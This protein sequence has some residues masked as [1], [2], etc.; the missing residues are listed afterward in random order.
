MP[1]AHSHPEVVHVELHHH[2]HEW[3][4][5][6]E[7]ESY[8]FRVIGLPWGPERWVVHVVFAEQP[9][10]DKFRTRHMT[11]LRGLINKSLSAQLG[12]D[13]TAWDNSLL[14]WEDK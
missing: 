7:P 3:S 10:P 9:A 11:M 2:P 6:E 13:I 14:S 8:R 4:N 1:T 12:R 5:G